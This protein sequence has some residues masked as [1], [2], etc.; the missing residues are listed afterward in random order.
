M[1]KL[2]FKKFWEGCLEPTFT[3]LLK[4]DSSLYI[5][6]G[7]YD[8]LCRYYNDIKNNTK[9]MFM[10]NS[11]DV[12]K[13][14]RHKISACMAKAIVLDRPVCKKIETDYTGSE[15]DFVI[16]NEVLAFSVAMAILKAYIK[17]K[18]ENKDA[19]FISRENEYTKIYESDF[20]FPNTIVSVDY[21]TSVCWAW[22]H[23]I[24]NGHFDV[25]GTANL[26]FMIENYSVEAYRNI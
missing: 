14:D 6:N 24:I 17:L 25:L 20:V 5:R 11:S 21:A 3:E 23:N 15:E 18:L 22:H 12:I 9:R 13:L 7:S 10:K 2:E 8:S 1:N 16:A 19:D 26:L 4:V